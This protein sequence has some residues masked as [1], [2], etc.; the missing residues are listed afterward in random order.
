MTQK[1]SYIFRWVLGVVFI[2]ASVY[3]IAYP[4]AFSE[5]I[6]N[7]KIF[8]DVL[9]NPLA[10]WLPWLELMAGLYIIIGLW[11]KGSALVLSILSLAFVIITGIAIYRGLDISCGC[12][13]LGNDQASIQWAHVAQ[14]I[15]LL[16]MS[17]QVLFYDKGTP[18]RD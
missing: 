17:L 13:S 6:S 4:C 10:I 16:A 15:G 9:I 7:Y 18:L 2:Y 8:P 11:V 5:A 14:N 3:K 12:F 1:L